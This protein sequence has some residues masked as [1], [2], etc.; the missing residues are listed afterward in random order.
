MTV[1]V[2]LHTVVLVYLSMQ[3][4]STVITGTAVFCTPACVPRFQV[5]FDLCYVK[6]NCQLNILFI[7]SP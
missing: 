6:A 7:F 2:M 1:Q 3:C 5:A 4:C